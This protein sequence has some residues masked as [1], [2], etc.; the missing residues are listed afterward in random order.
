[1]YRILIEISL[2]SNG[3]CLPVPGV[4]SEVDKNRI[5]ISHSIVILSND[6]VRLLG[7]SGVGKTTLCEKFLYP[8]YVYT[9][10]SLN[11]GTQLNRLDEDEMQISS[12]LRGQN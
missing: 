4:L 8:D 11:P 7:S 6:S 9:Y 2:T 5:S 3:S 12:N 1:M 10:D